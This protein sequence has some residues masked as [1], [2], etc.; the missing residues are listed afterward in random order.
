MIVKIEKPKFLASLSKAIGKSAGD[1]HWYSMMPVWALI[2]LSIGV[3]VSYNMPH[4]FWS[5]ERQSTAVLLYI[6]VFILDG[7]LISHCWA[8]FTRMYE[9]ITSPGFFSYLTGEELMPGY[10]V[11]IQLVHSVQLFAIFTSA[12]GLLL[13]LLSPPLIFNQVALAVT[14]F[15]AAYGLKTV[16]YLTHVMQDILWQKAIVEDFSDN[17]HRAEI[18]RF[19]RGADQL[20]EA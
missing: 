15:A 3:G 11:Y 2:C 1:W 16:S 12:V 6:G 17:Q 13:L 5:R 10:V 20:V 4:D 7:F 19:D 18:V 9:A 14:L 8:T